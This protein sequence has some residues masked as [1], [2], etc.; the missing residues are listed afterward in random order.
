MENNMT[1]EE[2]VNTLRL[3]VVNLSFTKV[4]DNAV[5]EM[6]AT[7]VEDMIPVDK[8]P[9]TDANANTEKNQLAVRVFDLDVSDWRSFRVDSLLTFN[10]L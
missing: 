4:K 1:Y 7:L 3:G 10:T 5:R 9:K 8:M 2:I 6:R